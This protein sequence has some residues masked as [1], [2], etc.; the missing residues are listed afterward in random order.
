VQGIAAVKLG[1]ECVL[2]WGCII[3]SI[4]YNSVRLGLAISEAIGLGLPGRRR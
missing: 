4:P 3:L 1:N 2:L